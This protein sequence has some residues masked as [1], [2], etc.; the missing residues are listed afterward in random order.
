MSRV[1][2]FKGYKMLGTLREG[3]ILS[4]S[5]HK[6]LL[7]EVTL[8]EVEGERYDSLEEA[9]AAAA[10]I[11]LKYFV[12]ALV[13]GS[14]HSSQVIQP[15]YRLGSVSV[16]KMAVNGGYAVGY[17][18]EYL[19]SVLPAKT[20]NQLWE[21]DGLVKL[22]IER[23]EDAVDSSQMMEITAELVWQICL[24]GQ[25]SMSSIKLV[26]RVQENPELFWSATRNL[27]RIYALRRLAGKD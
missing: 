7:Q 2:E 14:Q 22:D 25:K 16:R 10:G 3:V 8:W 1:T 15:A 20:R 5:E 17:L 24:G 4:D 13:Y 27:T 23:F 21:G 12:N 6:R 18:K 26:Q 11:P 9:N 19:T